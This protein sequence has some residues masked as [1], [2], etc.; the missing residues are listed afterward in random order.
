MPRQA[1][2][3]TYHDQGRPRGFDLA[4]QELEEIL[5]PILVESRCRLVGDNNLG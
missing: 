1:S 4:E 5:L 3:V 2:V